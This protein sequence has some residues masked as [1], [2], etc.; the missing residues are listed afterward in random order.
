MSEHR[1]PRAPGTRA[2]TPER[3]ALG[4]ELLELRRPLPMPCSQGRAGGNRRARATRTRSRSV[5]ETVGPPTLVRA[6]SP[7]LRLPVRPARPGAGPCLA[8]NR[9]EGAGDRDG[10]Q[11]G[12]EDTEEP[13]EPAADW[14]PHQNG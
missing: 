4:P 5:R 14:R 12:R 1:G 3:E 13:A 2:R 11:P 7:G 6:G 8:D 10:N 9:L